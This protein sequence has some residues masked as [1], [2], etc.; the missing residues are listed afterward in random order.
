MMN[1]HNRS[2]K[3]IQF[4]EKSVDF[5]ND[6]EESMSINGNGGLVQHK[7][8]DYLLN[9][10]SLCNLESM[11]RS[12]VAQDSTENLE[13]LKENLKKIKSISKSVER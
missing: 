10:G 5:S 9:D 4:L 13:D 1:K 3:S 6:M 2:N 7:S 12:V 11:D 8:P